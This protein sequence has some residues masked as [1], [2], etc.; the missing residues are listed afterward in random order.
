MNKID[1][2]FSKIVNPEVLETHE[3]LIKKFHISEKERSKT[4]GNIKEVIKKKTKTSFQKPINFKSYLDNNKYIK[5]MK[6]FYLSLGTSESLKQMPEFLKTTFGFRPPDF[7]VA[8]LLQEFQNNLFSKKEPKLVLKKISKKKVNSSNSINFKTE[9]KNSPQIL[10]KP[11]KILIYEK[12]DDQF[13]SSNLLLFKKEKIF[14][15][16]DKNIR[17]THINFYSDVKFKQLICKDIKKE[18]DKKVGFIYGD[19]KGQFL[20]KTIKPNITLFEKRF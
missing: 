11:K 3:N 8:N 13:K 18:S 9:P 20:G 19:N 6:N 12:C 2:I 17:S 16:L 14:D 4:T 15:K 1:Y 7:K 5:Y 10:N